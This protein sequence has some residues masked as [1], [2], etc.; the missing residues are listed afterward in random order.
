MKLAGSGERI[1]D[2][3]DARTVRELISWDLRFT[4]RLLVLLFVGLAFVPVS[5]AL[6]ILVGRDMRWRLTALY[7][8][9]T[10][11]AI[12]LLMYSRRRVKRTSA[13]NG[14]VS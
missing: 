11:V 7:A 13:A 3:D 12:F 5:G 8:A 6:L 2:P 14:W 10:A 9:S 4:H 1:D